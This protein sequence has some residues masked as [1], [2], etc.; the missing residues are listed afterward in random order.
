[1]SV[2]IDIPMSLC[3]Q[4]L[5]SKPELSRE[6][7]SSAASPSSDPLL[8]EGDKVTFEGIAIKL[9]K[10]GDFDRAKITRP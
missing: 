1:M 3:I 10:H 5:A 2:V 4:C 6:T 7:Y 8:H 9:I